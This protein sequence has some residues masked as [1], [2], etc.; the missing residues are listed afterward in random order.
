MLRFSAGTVPILV[1]LFGIPLEVRHVTL[2][3]ASLGYALDGLLLYGGLNRHDV[4]LSL[5]GV[6][7]VGVLNISTSFVLSFL[8]AVRARDV[9]DEKART[10][11]KEVGTRTDGES[12]RVSIVPSRTQSGLVARPC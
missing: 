11:L 3:A 2:S 5:L 1:A 7:L 6:L 10:F 8:L 9:G 12:E 4:M